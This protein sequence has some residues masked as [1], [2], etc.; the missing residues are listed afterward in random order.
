MSDNN[1]KEALPKIDFS[2]FINSLVA[3]ALVN[4]GI[5]QDTAGESGKNLSLAKQTIDIL[6]IIEEKTKNNLTDDENNLLINLL[7]DLRLAYVKAGKD[8]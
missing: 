6:G 2:T 8:S 5:M 3:S 1:K 7:H 4:L